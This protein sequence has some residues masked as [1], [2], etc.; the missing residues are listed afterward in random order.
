[1][2][3]EINVLALVKGREKYIWLYDDGH[4]DDTLRS[5]GAFA[6][7]YDLSFTWLDAARLSKR[8]RETRDRQEKQETAPTPQEPGWDR[9]RRPR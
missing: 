5:L 3:G 6:S 1:M 2:S 7:N 4:Y 9:P 8:V